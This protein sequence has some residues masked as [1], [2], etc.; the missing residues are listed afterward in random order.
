M[1]S[2]GSAVNSLFQA[3]MIDDII[4]LVTE[5]VRLPNDYYKHYIEIDI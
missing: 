3:V 4:W 2:F 1:S 5:T